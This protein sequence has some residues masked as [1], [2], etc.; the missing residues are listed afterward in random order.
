MQSQI[1]NFNYTEV[2]G[3]LQISG[4]NI[5]NLD[6]LSEL[7]TVGG[8]LWIQNTNLTNTDGLSSLTF[9]GD[10]IDIRTSQS[11]VSISLPS[12]TAYAAGGNALLSISENPS[13]T[14]VN[15]DALVT[16]SEILI[17]QNSSLANLS[18]ASLTSLVNMLLSESALTNLDG[19]SALT[20]AGFVI[21][22]NNPNL[23]ACCGA[24]GF[25]ENMGPQLAFFYSNQ[26]GCN[27]YSEIE[28]ECG[29]PNPDTDGDGVNDDVDNCPAVANP[30]QEDNDNDGAG[31][32]CDADDDNDG[33][34]DMNDN[35]SLIANA[36]QTDLDLDGLG[37]A[38]DATVNVCDAINGLIADVENLGLESGLENALGSKLENA[39]SSFQSCQYCNTSNIPQPGSVPEP[40]QWAS[41]HSPQCVGGKRPSGHFRPTGP[42]HLVTGN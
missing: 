33:I 41:Q 20:S 16:C 7:E 23:S 17:S 5:T 11:L 3:N 14:D 35:C 9:V 40:G 27:D 12:F 34:A 42:Q 10:F 18:F 24:W 39:I 26:L 2:T 38:C 21:I 29:D 31:D 1:D 13:L 37:D 36:D 32:A 4:N 8:F 28:Q 30:G 19:L 25:L 15:I 6:G 22:E